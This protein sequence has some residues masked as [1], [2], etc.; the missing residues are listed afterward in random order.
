MLYT[1][2]VCHQLRI[3]LSSPSDVPDKKAAAHEAIEDANQFLLSA[4]A[5][6]QYIA[7]VW[8]RSAIPGLHPLGPQG[9]IDEGLKIPECDLLVAIFSR[10]F[11]TALNGGGSG[12]EYEIRQAMKAW[13]EN[14]SPQVMMYFD[15]T[16]FS[17]SDP[18]EDGQFQRLTAFKKELLSLPLPPL[19]YQYEGTGD[20]RRALTKHLFD[21]A[22]V[23]H[24]AAP[25]RV[26]PLRLSASAT[27]MH[28]RSEGYTDLVGDIL[29]KCAC[30]EESKEMLWFSLVVYLN[31]SVTSRVAKQGPDS[32][33]EVILIEVGRA[34]TPEI[35]FGKVWGNQIAFPQVHLH[36]LHRGESRLFRITNIRCVSYAPR[37]T[38]ALSV[39]TQP[40][41]NSVLDVGTSTLGLA[42]K[43]ESG[44]L[45]D[46]TKEN[47]ASTEFVAYTPVTVE[48]SETFIGAF[49]T[50]LPSHSRPFISDDHGV[51]SFSETNPISPRVPIPDRPNMAG[52][53][54]TGTTG[55][56]L[57]LDKSA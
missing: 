54:D 35:Y 55:V 57:I 25:A 39:G 12:T 1:M 40:I 56:A 31:T 29:L 28:V 52:E 42:F 33:S 13:A 26:S 8:E 32:S 2:G 46:V 37:I 6:F 30:V 34:I 19:I 41:E 7:S 9:R 5:P 38:A 20:F 17:P 47:P 24:Q 3:V 21:T 51:V 11:G 23:R 15:S 36:G 18:E 44:A 4:S 50:K 14:G 43:A 53:A 45:V 48:F 16:P 27:V 22:M 49:K 10:R